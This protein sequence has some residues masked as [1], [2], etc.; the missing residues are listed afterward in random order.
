MVIDAG[1]AG[2][3]DEVF[4]TSTE[5]PLSRVAVVRPACTVADA[6]LRSMV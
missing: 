5:W 2:I 1:P 4:S 3:D 6:E